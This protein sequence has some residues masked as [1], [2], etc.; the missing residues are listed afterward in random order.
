[1]STKTARTTA[2]TK[3]QKKKKK[4]PQYLVIR[5]LAAVVVDGEVAPRV[6]VSVDLA[7]DRRADLLG[8][9]DPLFPLLDLLH[10]LGVVRQLTAP[11]PEYL[12]GA[13]A[14]RGGGGGTQV[15]HTRV[16]YRYNPGLR[17]RR[18]ACTVRE[19]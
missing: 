2:T 7:V 16:S 11:L 18:L 17:I 19:L 10:D 12:L 1:M 9:E 14:G 5:H 3:T 15:K 13:L 6:R 4:R 8:P